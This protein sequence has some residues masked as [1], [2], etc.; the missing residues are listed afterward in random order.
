[1]ELEQFKIV[2]IPLRGK[3]HNYARSILMNE[4]DAEDS[5]QETFLRLWSARTQLNSHPNVNGLAMTIIKNICI[6]KI[7]SK[8]SSVSLDDFQIIEDS[9]N[10][11]LSTEQNDSVKIIRKIIDLLPELQRQ[12][13][14]MRDVEGYELEEIAEITGSDAGTVRVYLSRARKKVRDKFM[15]I[16]ESKSLTKDYGK[17]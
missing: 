2:V 8:R 13:L 11:Y 9:K 5:V 14:L 12:I 16:N 15:S 1:M 10:P 17:Y 4:E 7:R 6:D 3:L